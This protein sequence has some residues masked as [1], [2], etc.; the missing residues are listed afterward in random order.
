MT[1]KGVHYDVGT[2]FVAG[3]LS[4][5]LWNSAD[6]VRDLQVIRNELHATHVNLYGSDLARL[7]EGAAF[8]LGAGLGVWIQ[9]RLI[10][11]DRRQ[12][13]AFLSQGAEV[14][15]RLRPRGEVVLNTGCELTVFTAGFIPGRTFLSRVSKLMWT[16]PLLPWYSARLNRHLADVAR[17]ARERFRGPIVYS[18]GSWER[19]RWELFDYVGVNLYRDRWNEKNYVSELRRLHGLGQ[20][21]VITEF[22]CCAFDGAERLGGGGWLIVDH[23]QTPA[24][25]KPGHD[26][27]EDVQARTIAELLDLYREENVHGAFV[28]DFMAASHRTH[29]DPALDL[30]RAGYGLVKVLPEEPGET[31][32][33]WER[34]RAFEEVARRYA[35]LSCPCE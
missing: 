34:K 15:E 8:A 28:Y 22:G 4:R 35:R 30:D 25:V 5:P 10:D 1:L 16:F 26:R 13:L 19:V 2:A 6:V 29:A 31:S 11:G 17:V 32:L 9:P 12:M 20:P 24:V 23:R 3:E 27:N 7:A 18:A 14:A 33:R 21:V